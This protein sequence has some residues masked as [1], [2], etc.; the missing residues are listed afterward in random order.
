[1]VVP[2]LGQVGLEGDDV[3]HPVELEAGL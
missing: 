3:A 1:L 2:P